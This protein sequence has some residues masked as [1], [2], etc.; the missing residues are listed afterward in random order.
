MPP[1]D[2]ETFVN[3]PG[4][5]VSNSR[6]QHL[7]KGKRVVTRA[8]FAGE[9][10]DKPPKRMSESGVIDEDKITSFAAVKCWAAT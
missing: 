5:S 8:D 3:S 4:F 9:Q 2:R 10:E 7:N 6:L 1:V